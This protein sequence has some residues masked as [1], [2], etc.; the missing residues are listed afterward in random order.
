MDNTLSEAIYDKCNSKHGGKHNGIL[1]AQ[2]S[3]G[4]ATVALH[5]PLDFLSESNKV[6][7]S[8]EGGSIRP[9]TANP[10]PKKLKVSN[11]LD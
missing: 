4:P 3:I 1:S 5:T 2:S 6:K 11:F 10:S 8:D 9:F 7:F